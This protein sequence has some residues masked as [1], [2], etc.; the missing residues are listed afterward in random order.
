VGRAV[1]ILGKLICS[2]ASPSVR[3]SS[4]QWRMIIGPEDCRVAYVG[5]GCAHHHSTHVTMLG[6]GQPSCILSR[7]PP[8]RCPLKAV[9]DPISGA[10]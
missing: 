8:L 1:S 6:I 4:I 3:D 5:Y 2:Y 10:P 9:D 7:W